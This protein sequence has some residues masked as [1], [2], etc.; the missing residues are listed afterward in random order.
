MDT[1]PPPSL[2]GSRLFRPSVALTGLFVLALFFALHEGRAFFLPIVVVLLLHFLL[3]PVI[4]ALKAARVPEALGAAAVL[5]GLLVA[6]GLA[7]YYLAG[8]TRDWLAQAP[9]SV[10][11]TQARRRRPW[12]APPAPRSR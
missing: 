5:G 9:A 8:P 6:L 1:L 3:S 11:Q 7:G 10:A 12:P 2:L 4:R